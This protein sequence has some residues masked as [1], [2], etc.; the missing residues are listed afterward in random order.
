[1]FMWARGHD[2]RAIEVNFHLPAGSSWKAA[3]Q[4]FPTD[5]PWV[6]T[7]PDFQYFMD[8]PTELS[9]FDLREW[10]VEGPDGSATFRLAVHH[11]GTAAE[12]D[13]YAEWVK[14]IVAEEIAV[15]GEPAPF[16]GGTYTFIADYLPW[17]SGDGMEHRNSTIL[18]SSSSLARNARG[19]IGTVSHE[20]FHSWNVERIRPR[21]L[22][23]F[24]FERANMSRELWFAEG[25]TS[26]YTAL[27]LKRAGI[28]DFE[29]YAT[30][31]VGGIDFVQNSPGRRFFGPAEMSM[32][33]PFVD[34]ST[35]I[36]PNNRT[37][38]FISYYT[39]G[40]VIGLGLDL[41]LRAR[42]G[43][44]LDDFMRHMWA[45]HG[46][47]E[48]PYVVEDIER[49]L[50]VFTGDKE[51][52]SDFFDRYVRGSELPDYSTLLS[53]AGLLLRERASDDAFL[54]G[55]RV[56]EAE[57]GLEVVTGTRIGSPLYEAGVDRGDLI[58]SIGDR[59]LTSAADW[60]AV[61]RTHAPGDETTIVFESR[62]RRK[63]AQIRFSADPRLEVVTFESAGMP[64]TDAM[65][66]FRG[67]WT[68][69]R[70]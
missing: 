17:A 69:S 58:A 11:T 6:F 45:V 12:V 32:Q 19:L 65:R 62:G 70:R 48:V 21:S 39:Y 20:F 60:Q 63:T 52:A 38:T 9:D 13:A 5:D 64:V 67:A 23:P 57:G 42:F 8:S 16:D 35:A 53:R 22:E 61:R 50:G 28:L 15:F 29:Q 30:G 26:Y 59:T 25:F 47:P 56:R 24:D 54:G 66:E 40:S 27:F 44:T 37:N 46:K 34:A 49:E 10:Q 31:L 36:D 68:D 2:G 3:T 55:A 51:F 14:A 1:T 7:A 33:A 18:S 41:T 43:Q 4:L